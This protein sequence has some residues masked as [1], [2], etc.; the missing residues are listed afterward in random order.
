MPEIGHTG[1]RWRLRGARELTQ[2]AFALEAE[3]AKPYLS[4]IEQGKVNPTIDIMDRLAIAFGVT[5]N[6]LLQAPDVGSELP[7]QMRPGRKP[8][9]IKNEKRP[10]RS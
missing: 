3:V 10:K 7:E 1:W 5:V 4:R 9:P 8:N 6:E 2:E